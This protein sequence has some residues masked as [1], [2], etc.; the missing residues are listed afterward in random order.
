MIHIWDTIET[1]DT[2]KSYL[3]YQPCEFKTDY[4]DTEHNYL[5]KNSSGLYLNGY[6]TIPKV[7]LYTLSVTIHH[8][9]RVTVPLLSPSWWGERSS[10]V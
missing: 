3:S 6:S 4:T 5:N 10:P 1:D 8:N 2:L 9:N 7:Y